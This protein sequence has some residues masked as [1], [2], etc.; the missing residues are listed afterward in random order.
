[1]QALRTKLLKPVWV[2]PWH[3]ILNPR[4]PG[5]PR[6]APTV[7]TNG[8]RWDNV[9]GEHFV[10]AHSKNEQQKPNMTTQMNLLLL[11]PI[12][13]HIPQNAQILYWET[14]GSARPVLF[15]TIEAKNLSWC[16]SLWKWN[17][18]AEAWK[19]ASSHTWENYKS[20]LYNYI[21]YL[22][23]ISFGSELSGVKLNTV[24]I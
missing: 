17:L 2:A 7:L 19:P 4:L 14:L 13:F 8:K 22:L 18:P 15:Q 6:L 5:F 3:T 1:M 12:H 11:I 16:L 10:S 23:A 9:I 24:F 21:T 20:Y